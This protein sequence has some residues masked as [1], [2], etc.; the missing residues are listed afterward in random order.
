M[1]DDRNDDLIHQLRTLATRPA[2]I[3]RDAL[4]FEAGR[5]QSRVGVVRPSWASRAQ[6]AWS[7]LA[8]CAAL[9][10][11]TLWWQRPEKAVVADRVVPAVEKQPE[12]TPPTENKPE[13]ALSSQELSPLPIAPTVS[14]ENYIARRQRVLE[15]GA[16][17]L[18]SPVPGGTSV[19]LVS[20]ITRQ[21]MLSE[22]EG[23]EARRARLKQSVSPWWQ[24]IL[25]SGDRS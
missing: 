21:E 17:V 18:D 13:A 20:P 15:G 19:A 8:T 14:T 1:N 6:R 3:D 22:F 25:T 16:E 12:Q 24:Q 5:A 7:V 10:F 2:A 4:M 23:P 11:A 9:T